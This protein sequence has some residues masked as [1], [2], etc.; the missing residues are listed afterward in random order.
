M[1]KLLLSFG[2]A[3]GLVL[4]AG[5]GLRAESIPWGYSA[6]DTVIYNNNSPAQSSS[7]QMA[8]SSGVA[9]GNS[10]IIIYNLTTSST[11]PDTAPDSFSNVPFNLAVTFTDIKATGSSSATAK[12]SDVVTFS[13]LF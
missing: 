1:K 12:S 10:G 6:A 9:S 3:L 8:G 2:T 7:V 5:S 13:G 4:G 11:S